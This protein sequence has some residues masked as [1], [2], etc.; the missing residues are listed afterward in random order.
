MERDG[1]EWEEEGEEEGEE[2]EEEDD[3]GAF[4]HL[5]DSLHPD[6]LRLIS[7]VEDDLFCGRASKFLIRRQIGEERKRFSA[8][9]EVYLYLAN[10]AVPFLRQLLNEFGSSRL[11]IWIGVE[12]EYFKLLDPDE[13]CSRWS[14]QRN[15]SV[16][17]PQFLSAEEKERFV[18]QFAHQFVDSFLHDVEEMHSFVGSSWIFSKIM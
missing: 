9:E 12:A 16:L 3:E 4:Y 7:S 5:L 14:S 2:E 17:T 18:I 8:S 6:Q 11:Y 15:K 13:T 10:K 1:E